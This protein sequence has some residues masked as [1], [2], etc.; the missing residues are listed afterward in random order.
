MPCP[1]PRCGARIG[2]RHDRLFIPPGKSNA[3]GSGE[4]SRVE[5]EGA[6]VP[7]KKQVLGPKG[8]SVAIQLS[9]I[10]DDRLIV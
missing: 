2:D 3:L 9:E 10:Q 6:Y 5:A 8:G 7:Q 4:T 1:R